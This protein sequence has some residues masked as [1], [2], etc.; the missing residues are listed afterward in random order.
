MNNVAVECI[1]KAPIA[2]PVGACQEHTV[3]AADVRHFRV[4]EVDRRQAL[5]PIWAFRSPRIA[6]VSGDQYRAIV[7]REPTFF[8]VDK[9]D[10]ANF[11]R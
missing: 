9:V 8:A 6:A 1:S 11:Y 4:A 5:G 3:V 10:I 2:A 7:A